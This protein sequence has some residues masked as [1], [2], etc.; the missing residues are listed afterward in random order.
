M[1]HRRGRAVPD[2]E[3]LAELGRPLPSPDL[4]RAIMRRLALGDSAASIALLSSLPS[5]V[6]ALN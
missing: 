4:T 1:T 2:S 6:S 5:M 3:F